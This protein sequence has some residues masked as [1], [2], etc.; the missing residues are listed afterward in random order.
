MAINIHRFS[1]SWQQGKLYIGV[2]NVT[3]DS[4]VMAKLTPDHRP[5]RIRDLQHVAQ[6]EQSSAAQHLVPNVSPPPATTVTQ[7]PA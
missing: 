6:L 2:R 4:K 1:C 7:P 5:F 3:S